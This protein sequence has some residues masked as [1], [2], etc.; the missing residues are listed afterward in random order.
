MIVHPVQI[1]RDEVET[2]IE[3][4]AIHLKADLLILNTMKESQSQSENKG[5]IDVSECHYLSKIRRLVLLE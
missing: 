1:I 3:P 4:T 2:I 5:M